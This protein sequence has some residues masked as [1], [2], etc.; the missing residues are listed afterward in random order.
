ML[1]RNRFGIPYSFATKEHTLSETVDLEKSPVE[2]LVDE[3]KSPAKFNFAD[4]IN[5]VS[6]P[7]GSV[8]IFLNGAKAGELFE[9]SAEIADLE[10][11]SWK[12]RAGNNGGIVDDDE[13]EEYDKH[14]AVLTA[15]QEVLIKEIRA[16]KMTFHMRGVTPA[17]VSAI[18]MKARATHKIPKTGTE[19]DVVE[20]QITRN[21]WVN[22]ALVSHAI[23]KIVNAAGDEDTSAFTV[24]A[25]T[26]LRD[27]LYASEWEKLKTKME[28]LSFATNLFAKASEQDADFL[29]QP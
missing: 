2:Q 20:A 13:A 1:N 25:A 6:F 27:V 8:D 5:Q 15:Q 24:E 11:D 12:H 4:A 19:E 26:Q 17:V 22:E 23:T 9:V 7:T 18:D 14:I 16:S 3:M 10:K 29:P 28:E 21:N